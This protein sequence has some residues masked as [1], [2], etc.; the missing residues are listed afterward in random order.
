[1]A[2]HEVAGPLVFNFMHLRGKQ[3]ELED[4]GFE[5]PFHLG[6]CQRGNVVKARLHQVLDLGAFDHASIPHKRHAFAAKA[7]AKL[8]VIRDVVLVREHH[9]AHAAE[10]VDA[11]DEQLREPR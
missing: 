4:V 3:G 10:R 2:P 7:R 1:M 6:L 11:I 9:P 5:E 8:R